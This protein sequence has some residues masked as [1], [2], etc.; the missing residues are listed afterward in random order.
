MIQMAMAGI[1]GWG[2]VGKLIAGKGMNGRAW[3]EGVGSFVCPKFVC[4]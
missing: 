2:G 4:P 1:W 3:K